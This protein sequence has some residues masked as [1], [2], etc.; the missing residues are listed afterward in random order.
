[1]FKIFIKKPKETKPNDTINITEN[2]QEKPVKKKAFSFFNKPAKT[3]EKR[4]SERRLENIERITPVKIEEL[5][6]NYSLSVMLEAL[7][8]LD[9]K[10]EDITFLDLLEDQLFLLEKNHQ[11]QYLSALEKKLESIVTHIKDYKL[12]DKYLNI[13]V[14][15]LCAKDLDGKTSIGMR[16]KSLGSVMFHK[17][18]LDFSTGVLLLCYEISNLSLSGNSLRIVH[19]ITQAQYVIDTRNYIDLLDP[20]K[21]IQKKASFHDSFNATLDLVREEHEYRKSLR[22]FSS[23]QNDSQ[24][25]S[26][27]DI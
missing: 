6:D 2:K 19:T 7:K 14:K 15:L 22:D 5:K 10:L 26:N 23:P 4:L 17:K 13:Y 9:N 1:M 24:N 18:V 8:D 21:S 11:H 25:E 3:E 20:S 12:L 16:I 27:S